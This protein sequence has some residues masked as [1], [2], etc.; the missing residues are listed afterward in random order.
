MQDQADYL[1]LTAY[2]RGQSSLV[3][4]AMHYLAC[5]CLF[6]CLLASL[7]EL[8]NEGMRGNEGVQFRAYGLRWI[9]IRANQ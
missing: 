6:A 4:T 3:L 2:D 5:V 7:I 9:S 1:L 8:S